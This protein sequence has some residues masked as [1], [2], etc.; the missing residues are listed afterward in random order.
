M[1]TL[2]VFAA[3]ALVWI[4]PWAAKL[5]RWRAFLPS[6]GVSGPAIGLGLA[7]FALGFT[8]WEVHGW[9]QARTAGRDKA[10]EIATEAQQI[11]TNANQAARIAALEK[12][13][14]EREA[15]AK[16]EAGRAAAALATLKLLTES[17]EAARHASPNPD[18]I[19]IPAGDPWLLRGP[20]GVHG[21]ASGPTSGRLLDLRAKPG[22][23]R[24]E[25]AVGR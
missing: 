23:G 25:G 16:N 4:G 2:A 7:L 13:L 3:K 14:G 8:A 11:C 19:L 9:L 17:Q 6:M 24:V 18:Q 20:F 21:A 5:A 15:A 12:A 10:T 1:P 22:R